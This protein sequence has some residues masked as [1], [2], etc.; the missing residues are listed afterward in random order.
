MMFTQH[1]VFAT[2]YTN[3]N[4]K[5]VASATESN[6]ENNWADHDG[7]QDNLQAAPH[8]NHENE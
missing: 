8:T 5:D 7:D 6:H 1:A 2:P 3:E 4:N